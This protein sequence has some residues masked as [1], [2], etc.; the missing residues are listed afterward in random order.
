MNDNLV[1]VCQGAPPLLSLSL[2]L[3]LVLADVGPAGLKGRWLDTWLLC[4]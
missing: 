3:A 4:F 2:S 1:T